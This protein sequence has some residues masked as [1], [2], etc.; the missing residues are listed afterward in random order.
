MFY[1]RYTV[2]VYGDGGG[3]FHA[4]ITERENTEPFVGS[5]CDDPIMA[6][7]LAFAELSSRIETTIAATE[8]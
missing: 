7:G 5:G 1:A 6:A 8:G 4:E 2:T 3:N